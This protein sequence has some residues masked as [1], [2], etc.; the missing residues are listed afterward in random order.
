L[1]TYISNEKPI[2]SMV[3]KMTA[4]WLIILTI[5]VCAAVPGMLIYLTTAVPKTA[6]P[7]KILVGL[8]VV[9]KLLP[10]TY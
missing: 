3:E 7:A 10:M 6:A 5:L 2:E 1:K 4:V 8:N 9:G